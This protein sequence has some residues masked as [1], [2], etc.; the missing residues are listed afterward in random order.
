VHSAPRTG[1]SVAPQVEPPR[2]WYTKKRYALS[3]LLLLVL[4][5]VLGVS[6]I[7]GTHSAAADPAGQTSSTA[8]VDA[9]P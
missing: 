6:R 2:L 7:G 9:S 3:F 8:A 1:A 4:L 5:V